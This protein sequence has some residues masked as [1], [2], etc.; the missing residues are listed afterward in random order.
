M[1]TLKNIVAAL[2]LVMAV[3]GV[4]LYFDILFNVV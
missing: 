3:I 2:L 4:L 1:N